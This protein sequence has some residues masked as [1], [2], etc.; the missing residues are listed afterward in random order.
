M[1]PS[2][3]PVAVTKAEPPARPTDAGFVRQA[4]L[5]PTVEKAA[6]APALSAPCR[7]RCSQ[8]GQSRPLHSRPGGWSD[9]LFG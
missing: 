5:W 7:R 2:A 1:G 9:S 6:S 4:F 3:L 8:G